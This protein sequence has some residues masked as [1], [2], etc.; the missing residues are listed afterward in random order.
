MTYEDGSGEALQC[1]HRPVFHGFENLIS[2]DLIRR[3]CSKI[4]F[5]WAVVPL[6]MAHLL[7]LLSDENIKS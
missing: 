5:F 4:T 3:K 7:W 2:F 1:F 6:A